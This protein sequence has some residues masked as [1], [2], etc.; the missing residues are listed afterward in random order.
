MELF[1]GPLGPSGGEAPLPSRKRLCGRMLG[2]SM[3][4]P[5][6]YVFPEVDWRCFGEHV[7]DDEHEGEEE[8]KE[9]H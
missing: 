4:R 9:E 6:K 3:A 1:L 2:Q 7:G 5:S 8:G